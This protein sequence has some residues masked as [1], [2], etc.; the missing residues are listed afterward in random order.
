[1][2]QTTREAQQLA[3][4]IIQDAGNSVRRRM[5]LIILTDEDEKTRTVGRVGVRRLGKNVKTADGE[6]MTRVK[7]TLDALREGE[8]IMVMY[9]F[10][11]PELDDRGFAKEALD[12]FIPV[13]AKIMGHKLTTDS[14]AEDSQ[15]LKSLDEN[16]IKGSQVYQVIDSLE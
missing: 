6:L 12:A 16:P 10:L 5:E 14:D 8:E 11:D 3:I 4:E 2:C 13:S 9:I 7:K 15:S 1:L